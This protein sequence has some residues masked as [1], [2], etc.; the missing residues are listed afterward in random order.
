MTEQK[1]WKR[2][3]VVGVTAVA[4][5]AGAAAVY[6]PAVDAAALMPSQ[7]ALGQVGWGGPRGGLGQEAGAVDQRAL[8][9]DALGIT[10]DELQAAYD[11]VNE[12]V[13]AQMVE[14]GRITQDQADRMVLWGGF[15]L[16]GGRG[17]RSA[18]GLDAESLLAEELGVSVEELADAREEVQEAAVQQAITEGLITQEE[19]DEME[20]IQQLRSYLDQ[21]ALL[22]EALGVTVDE[23]EGMRED[24]KALSALVDELGLD[25]ATVRDN[26]EAAREAAIQK[27]VADGVITQDQ[28]DEILSGQGPGMVHGRSVPFGDDGMKRFQGS[29]LQPAPRA[30]APSSG[31]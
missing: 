9:A 7:T 23:L 27:A 11:A 14:E 30:F 19:A 4:L 18:D 17:H 13:L 5:S 1:S 29:G 24:G 10:E 28:A 8:L 2:I 12:G 6:S 21:D 3:V 15:G 25:M 26:L 22:A 20:A 16:L 31:L